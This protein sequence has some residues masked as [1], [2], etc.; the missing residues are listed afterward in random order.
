MARVSVWRTSPSVVRLN[1][2]PGD[3]DEARRREAAGEPQGSTVLVVAGPTKVTGSS[4]ESE[5]PSFW[6]IAASYGAIVLLGIYALSQNA[7]LKE[8]LVLATGASAFAL[9]YLA[10]QTVERLLE[11]LTNWILPKKKEEKDADE[12]KAMAA[13][14]VDEEATTA[15]DDAAKKA[16][17]LQRKTRE[18]A[19]LFWGIT[20]VAGILMSLWLGVYFLAALLAPTEAG[21]DPAV[22]RWADAV[23]TGVVIGGGSKGLHDLITRVQ[24]PAET[25]SEE[26]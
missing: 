9:F 6:V 22:P 10:A 15:A 4:N 26:D 17:L 8:P 20:S 11:P 13:N 18:R 7:N 1:V 5:D 24:K 23:L 2:P 25:G 21:S 16:A 19:I 12:A 3:G 14:A